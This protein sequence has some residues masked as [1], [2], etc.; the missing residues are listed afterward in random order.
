MLGVPGFR[1]IA[2]GTIVVI[3]AHKQIAFGPFTLDPTLGTLTRDGMPMA[4][5]LRG[6]ALLQALLEANGQVVA[7]GEL[8]ERAWPGAFVEEGN[9]TVQI[10][11]LR[12]ALGDGPDGQPWIVTVP[13]TGYRLLRAAARLAAPPPL[14]DQPAL[15]V[16][17]FQ[18]L[19][20]D[21]DQDY[22]AD[23]VATEIIAALA[24]FRSFAV[25]SHTSSFAYKGRSVD[26]R[27]VASD[28]GVRYV[29]EGSLQ[30][31]GDRLRITAH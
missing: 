8:I 30:R 18:N 29:L 27:E 15:A 26:V 5:G 4:I 28:L 22:I 14:R 6:L 23:G 10:A 16:L 2:R 17:P 20:G 7:K 13:R 11:A 9:L 3:M 12:K 31:T 25:V 21:T 19:G 24:R 1:A